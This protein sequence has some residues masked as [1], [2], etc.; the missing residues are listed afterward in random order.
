MS[1]LGRDAIKS[2]MAEEKIEDRL[3]ITP[4]LEDT[5]IS[6]S[7]VDIRL[8]HN[9]IVTKKGAVPS[10]D[11]TL[12]SNPAEYQAMHRVNLREKFYL[13]PKELVLAGTLEYFRLPTTVNGYVTSR[14]VGRCWL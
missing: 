13:H 5:Q 3:I 7:S 1:V 2:L 14:E 8:G 12:H 9:F 11:P 4:L 10:I 6:Q